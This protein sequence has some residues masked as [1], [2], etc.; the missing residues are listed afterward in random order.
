MGVRN[1]FGHLFHVGLVRLKQS[2]DVAHR[3]PIDRARGAAKAGNIRGEVGFKVLQGGAD[4]SSNAI[5]VFELAWLL[6]TPYS[7]HG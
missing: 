1:D 6:T 4:D 7:L 2:P 3:R 5:R